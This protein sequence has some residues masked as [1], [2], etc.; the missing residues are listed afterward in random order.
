[1]LTA[2][3]SPLV[4][5]TAHTMDKVSTKRIKVL[6]P[7]M[8]KGKPTEVG[9]VLDVDLRTAAEVTTS[10][11]AVLVPAEPKAEVKAEPAKVEPPK[12][13]AKTTQKEG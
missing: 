13:A 12:P 2:S 1:M 7:F 3:N 11:K 10:N 6:R 9:A 5:G 8:H 4:A